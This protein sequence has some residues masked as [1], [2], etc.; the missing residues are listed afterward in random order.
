MR[1]NVFAVTE[2]EFAEIIVR[3]SRRNLFIT[4]IINCFSVKTVHFCLLLQL[5]NTLLKLINEEWKG[6]GERGRKEGK[7]HRRLFT[8]TVRVV[9]R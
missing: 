2:K 4:R 9:D 7:L 8:M 1:R 6:R 5:I 3:G